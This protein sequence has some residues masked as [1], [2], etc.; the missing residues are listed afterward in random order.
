MAIAPFC[1]TL[2]NWSVDGPLAP[3]QIRATLAA[4]IGRPVVTLDGVPSE[5]FPDGA[6][7]CDVWHGAGDFPVNVD[8]YA[9]P[10]DPPEHRVLAAFARR[11]GRR[12]VLAD[13][14]L[15]ATRH[16]LV[17][18]DGT[19]RPVHLDIEPTGVGDRRTNLRLCSLT[20][21]GCRAGLFCGGS[22]WGPD[23]VA[24]TLAA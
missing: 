22:R 2:W 19:V 20:D 1:T 10:V 18:P 14:T 15:D 16:L 17:S 12:C 8:C 23:S 7:L 24:P 9:A 11:T 5:R 21:P 3:G 6:V 4:I 13:D